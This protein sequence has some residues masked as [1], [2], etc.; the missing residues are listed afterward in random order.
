MIG[1]AATNTWRLRKARIE[2]YIMYGSFR[3]SETIHNLLNGHRARYNRLPGPNEE[4]FLEI[5]IQ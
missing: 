4:K 1:D 2:E 5:G 3:L